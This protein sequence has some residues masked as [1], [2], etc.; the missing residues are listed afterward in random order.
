MGTKT[1]RFFYHFIIYGYSVVG[2]FLS[3]LNVQ[4]YKLYFTAVED[5]V[6]S[7]LRALALGNRV[8]YF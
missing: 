8:F 7:K 3:K 2:N 4:F 1:P 6:K 5:T